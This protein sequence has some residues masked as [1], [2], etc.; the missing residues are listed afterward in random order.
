[1]N[2]LRLSI[3]LGVA[4]GLSSCQPATAAPPTVVVDRTCYYP[5]PEDQSTPYRFTV[6]D[7]WVELWCGTRL[8]VTGDVCRV[9]ME[10]TVTEVPCQR[11]NSGSI[12][13]FL[14]DSTGV[15]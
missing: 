2:L 5:S 12:A 14:G 1:M 3:V 10:P 13:S 6:G 15:T 7:T 4:L 11:G 8:E 9:R